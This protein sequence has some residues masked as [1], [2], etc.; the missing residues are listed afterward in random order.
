MLGQQAINTFLHVGCFRMEIA[1]TVNYAK[2]NPIR[3]HIMKLKLVIHLTLSLNLNELS[4]VASQM[5]ITIILILW[6]F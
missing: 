2:G 1:L 3:T 4:T 5:K 6:K